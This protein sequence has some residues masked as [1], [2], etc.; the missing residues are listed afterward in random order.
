MSQLGRERQS[1]SLESG[2]GRGTKLLTEPQGLQPPLKPALRPAPVPVPNSRFVALS[3]RT[4]CNTHRR[5]SL[6][7]CRSP[8]KDSF[9]LVAVAIRLLCDRPQPRFCRPSL[10][11]LKSIEQ[12]LQPRLLAPRLAQMTQDPT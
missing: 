1:R 4:L 3:V 7:I 12:R 9:S 5:H 8:S 6:R 10:A 2:R 11:Q